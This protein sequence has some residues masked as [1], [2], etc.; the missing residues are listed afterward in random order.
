MTMSTGRPLSSLGYDS[1]P[2]PQDGPR[3]VT[4][5]EVAS[6]LRGLAGAPLPYSDSLALDRVLFL[7]EGGEGHDRPVAGYSGAI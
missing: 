5:A 2:L 1:Q 4:P 7:L 6:F 3:P